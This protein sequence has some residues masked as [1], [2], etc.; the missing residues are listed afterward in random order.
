MANRRLLIAL[1]TGLG[2]INLA[3]CGGGGGGGTTAPVSTSTLIGIAAVGAP[4]INGSLTA[5]CAD[6]SG[7]TETVVT[8]ADGTWSGSVAS[9]ALP[10]ALQITGGTPAVTLHSLATTGGVTNI[11]PLTDL[12]LALATG[13]DPAS[14]FAAYNGAAVDIDNATTDLLDALDG[15]DFTIP[16]GNPFTTLFSANGTGWDGLLDD[17]QAALEADSTTYSAL[18][19]L[20]R[21]GNLAS[22]PDAPP[23]P[24]YTI[25][26]SISGATGN[27]LWQT[28]DDGF[29]HHD[30]SDANGAVTFT[31][32]AGIAGGSS[33]SVEITGEPAGQDCSISNGSGIL[34]ANVTNVQIT[35]EDEPAEPVFYSIS[36]SISGA[37]GNVLWQTM[38]DGFVHHD[39]SDTDGAVTFTTGAGIESGSSW[40]VE[41]TGEPTGQSCNVSNGSGTLSANIT[42]VLISCEAESTGSVDYDLLQGR[43]GI[44]LRPNG[45][46]H[47]F[48]LQGANEYAGISSLRRNFRFG[49]WTNWPVYDQVNLFNGSVVSTTYIS[50]KHSP[51]SY[52]CGGD[53][54]SI[55]SVQLSGSA[56]WHGTFT[57][58]TC[59]IVV[60]HGSR[61]GGFMGYVASATLSNGSES[62]TVENA[63][64]RLYQH[65]GI[66]GEPPALGANGYASLYIEEPGVFE[67]PGGQH[68]ILDNNPVSAGYGISPDDGTVPFTGN[69]SDVITLNN[70]TSI[71]SGTSA[72]NTGSAGNLSTGRYL[73]ELPYVA[74][75]TGGSCSRT[76]AGSAGGFNWSTYTATLIASGGNTDA[77]IAESARTVT[78]R[79]EVRNFM[80]NPVVARNDG[81][82]GALEEADTGITVSIDEGNIHFPEEQRFR[83]LNSGVLGDNTTA[84]ASYQWPEGQMVDAGGTRTNKGTSIGIALNQLPVEPGVYICNDTETSPPRVLLDSSQGVIYS[85]TTA[86]FLKTMAVGASCSITIDTVTP[87]LTG[88]Y[89]ATVVGPAGTSTIMPDGDAIISISGS[90]RLPAAP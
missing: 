80:L 40:S 82:E 45:S 50:V 20:V 89:T 60:E 66:S 32:G 3:A 87:M 13:L 84:F 14:W 64:F 75:V 47:V 12:A 70:I 4:I 67:F 44:A 18:L 21:E 35:C 37:T 43:N 46:G 62:F 2:S 90:F 72:C 54:N 55:F 77:T 17:I 24:S 11:T 9:D 28:M 34:S 22:L 29:V 73:G 31:S 1:I 65:V 78:I 48:L 81:D 19:A 8:A 26:G 88:S 71:A 58:S 7:F 49:P 74:N 69:A 85:T 6:G 59:N 79:G 38:D 53:D 39:G 5:V 42:N 25:S 68:F 41:I 63:P 51:G 76:S 16:A 23:P 52:V 83:F 36:G 86:S 56:P 30:G 10:C 15:K 61:L 57:A 27:V 33:W